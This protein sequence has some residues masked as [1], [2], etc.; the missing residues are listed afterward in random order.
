MTEP[1]LQ[2]LKKL[3]TPVPPPAEPANS[4]QSTSS[5]RKQVED[6]VEEKP[7]VT[8][9]ECFDV[10]DSTRETGS[11][12]PAPA[13][14]SI[15]SG[16]LPSAS[17]DASTAT[18]TPPA[19]ASTSAKDDASIDRAEPRRIGK[20]A[21]VWVPEVKEVLWRAVDLIPNIGRSRYV[22]RG[23]PMDRFDMIA[24]YIRRQSGH[25]RTCQQVRSFTSNLK[26]G[27]DEGS[28]IV[29]R[30][31]GSYI[32]SSVA[33]SIDWDAFLGPDLHPAIAPAETSN[34]QPPKKRKRAASQSPPPPTSSTATGADKRATVHTT[35]APDKPSASPFAPPPYSLQPIYQPLQQVPGGSSFPST[36][37]PQAVYFLPHPSSRM[38]YRHPN[39]PTAQTQPSTDFR[40]SLRAFFAAVMPDR[41]FALLANHLASAG[42]T[43]VDQLSNLLLMD[44]GSVDGFVERI[45][46]LGGV[47][48]AFLRKAIFSA[49]ASFESLA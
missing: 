46:K 6:K 34:V 7:L 18:S 39:Q 20:K 11:V 2:T 17:P 30:L 1:A 13:Q 5:A 40:P 12:T 8:V 43:S 24:E 29:R 16:P 36:Q 3:P 15:P 10:S 42:I 41:D 27:Q 22:V 35:R 48:R 4:P 37:Q 26:Y 33:A 28:E 21:T 25:R 45:P 38:L 32:D 31:A 49:K 14:S 9:E 19:Q 23:T 47:E 44:E